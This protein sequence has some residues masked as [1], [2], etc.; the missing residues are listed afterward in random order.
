MDYR[1]SW[2]DLF[3]EDERILI[4]LNLNRSLWWGT[5]AIGRFEERFSSVWLLVIR[6]T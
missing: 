1:L 5:L 2:L 6:V 3:I 4:R